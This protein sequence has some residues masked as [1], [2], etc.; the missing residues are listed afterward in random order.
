MKHIFR[1]MKG[2]GST[3][4]CM[5]EGFTFGEMEENMMENIKKTKNVGSE[6]T[7]GVMEDATKG[8]GTMENNVVKENTFYQTGQKR[9]EIGIK[10]EEC[11]GLKEKKKKI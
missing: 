2:N 1:N 4:K 7:Y 3:I 6:Y 9:W 8:S 5:E 11:V 10:E